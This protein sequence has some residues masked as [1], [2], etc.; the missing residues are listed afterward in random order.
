MAQV[1]DRDMNYCVILT[2]N[3]SNDY[4]RNARKLYLLNMLGLGLG[5]ETVVYTVYMSCCI[6]MTVTK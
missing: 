3:N 6:L 4:V 2:E 1:Y 5:H